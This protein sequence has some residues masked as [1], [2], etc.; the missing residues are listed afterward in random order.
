MLERDDDGMDDGMDDCIPY[1]AILPRSCQP[2]S[3]P[4]CLPSVADSGP[5]LHV[6]HLSLCASVFTQPGTAG[7]N[8]RSRAFTDFAGGW[9]ELHSSLSSVK[10][11]LDSKPL[12]LAS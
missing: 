6:C 3:C 7:D 1:G 4:T 10:K 12:H 9:E 5:P 11:R 2:R 8:Q